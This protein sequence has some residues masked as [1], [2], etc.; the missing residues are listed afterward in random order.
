MVAETHAE[1]THDQRIMGSEYV[2]CMQS[3][4]IRDKPSQVTGAYK[5]VMDAP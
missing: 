1:S 3:A 4:A 2:P 5:L